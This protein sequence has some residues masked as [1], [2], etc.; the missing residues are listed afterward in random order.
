MAGYEVSVFVVDVCRES[1]TTHESI[2]ETTQV[3]TSSWI[4]NLVSVFRHHVR[5]KN[6]IWYAWI[7]T[8][9]SQG[10]GELICHSIILTPV[11]CQIDIDCV[12]ANWVVHH[13][14]CVN[15]DEGITID[16]DHSDIRG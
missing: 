14:C 13:I 6:Q 2:G 15:C 3:W 10:E 9:D 8:C 11:S 1:T 7:R 4:S 5:G 12:R 16:L